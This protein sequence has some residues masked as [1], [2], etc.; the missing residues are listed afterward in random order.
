LNNKIQKLLD[1]LKIPNKNIVLNKIN[2]TKK[3]DEKI[4]LD[5]DDKNFIEKYFEKDFELINNIKNH[6]ELFRLVI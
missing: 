2:I 3:I 6:P 5:E 4:I 1:I